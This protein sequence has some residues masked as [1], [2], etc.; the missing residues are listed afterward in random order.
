MKQRKQNLN[1]NTDCNENIFLDTYGYSKNNMVFSNNQEVN[2]VDS[3]L[4]A[5]VLYYGLCTAEIRSLAYEYA[6]QL[7]LYA[8][9]M[10]GKKN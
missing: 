9:D 5:S 6:D 3:L 4:K 7:G 8:K 10:V 2:L 1:Q